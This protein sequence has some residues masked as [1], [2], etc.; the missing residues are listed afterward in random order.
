MLIPDFLGIRRGSS[1]F[2]QRYFCTNIF[3]IISYYVQN[4]RHKMCINILLDKLLPPS[5]SRGLKFSGVYIKSYYYSF[6]FFKRKQQICETHTLVHY[7]INCRINF[8]ICV[9]YIHAIPFHRLQIS[10]WHFPCIVGSTFMSHTIF[11]CRMAKFWLRRTNFIQT[12]SCIIQNLGM[13]EQGFKGS[14]ILQKCWSP[15]RSF[16]NCPFMAIYDWP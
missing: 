12:L 13:V 7:F 14:K 5:L 16:V 3:T 6:F 15:Q 1:S 8:I 9:H 2:I 4:V 10:W 11:C